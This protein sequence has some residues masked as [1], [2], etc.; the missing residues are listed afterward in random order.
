MFL[1]LKLLGLVIF[2]KK[3]PPRGAAFWRVDYRLLVRF[4]L[5]SQACAPSAFGK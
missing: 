4:A 3:K 5:S 2:G 1:R